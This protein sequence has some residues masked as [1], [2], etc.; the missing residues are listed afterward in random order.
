MTTNDGA[1]PVKEP[2]QQLPSGTTFAEAF[3]LNFTD[4][5]TVQYQERLDRIKE[6]ER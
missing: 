6:N 5:S 2:G 4:D 3:G 1:Y